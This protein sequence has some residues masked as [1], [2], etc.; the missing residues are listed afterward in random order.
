MIHTARTLAVIMAA[1]RD[2]N[3]MHGV[4]FGANLY[5]ANTGVRQHDLCTNQD[6]GSLLT[7][8]QF[9][10]DAGAKV[11]VNSWGSNRRA[12]I[13]PCWCVRL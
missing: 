3:E 8:L 7:L 11:I 10:A 2:G 13:H 9:L 5:S 12:S 6:Y 4:A 1:S